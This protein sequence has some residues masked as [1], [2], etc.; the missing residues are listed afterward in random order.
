MN[1]IKKAAPMES[2]PERPTDVRSYS[3]DQI[4]PHDYSNMA[5]KFEQEKNRKALERD[6]ERARKLIADFN[7]PSLKYAPKRTRWSMY[8]EAKQILCY[9]GLHHKAYEYGIILLTE[10]LRL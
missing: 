9:A 2:A 4:N 3:V 10:W 5:A 1:E 6:K 7:S 8:E